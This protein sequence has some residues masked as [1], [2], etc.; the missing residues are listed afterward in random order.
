MGSEEAQ[1]HFVLSAAPSVSSRPASVFSDDLRGGSSEDSGINTVQHVA[2]IIVRVKETK[3]KITSHDVSWC[4]TKLSD[5]NLLQIFQTDVRD[6]VN[7]FIP[8]LHQDLVILTKTQVRQPVSQIGLKHTKTSAGKKLCTDDNE[9][10]DAKEMR[11]IVYVSAAKDNI[12]FL[13]V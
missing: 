7:V 12:F 1:T 4:L 3:I 2:L 8:I 13:F 5:A 9:H 6:K 10:S 11:S